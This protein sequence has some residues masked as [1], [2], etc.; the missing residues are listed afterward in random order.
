MKYLP[1]QS[2]NLKMLSSALH[3]E[4]QHDRLLGSEQVSHQDETPSCTCVSSAKPNTKTLPTNSA[5]LT[6]SPQLSNCWMCQWCWSWRNSKVYYLVI[7]NSK[8]SNN[9]QGSRITDVCKKSKPVGSIHMFHKQVMTHGN[10]H[11]D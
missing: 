8:W 9:S 5:L 3:V 2:W 1:N 6:H 10:G 11:I 7:Q 4:R